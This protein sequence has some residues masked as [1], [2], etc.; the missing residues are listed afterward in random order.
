MCAILYKYIYIYARD[1]AEYFGKFI[2]NLELKYGLNERRAN[3]TLSMLSIIFGGIAVF[4]GEIFVP[5]AVAY[6]SAL[7]V[8]DKTKKHILTL[9]VG[10]VILVINV[11]GIIFSGYISLAGIMIAAVSSVISFYVIRDRSKNECVLIVTV[12]FTLLL[13]ASFVLALMSEAGQFSFEA[14]RAIYNELYESIRSGFVDSLAQ[15]TAGLGEEAS[16]G[17]ISTEDM[18]MIFDS[19]ANLIIAFA[20]IASFAL[21][22][23]S[24]RCFNFVVERNA[25]KS[26]RFDEWRFLPP[27]IF[28]YFYVAVFLISFF[29]SETTV[30]SVAVNNLV[31]IFMAIFLYPGFKLTFAFLSTFRSRGFAYVAIIAALMLFSTVTLEFISMVGVF[32]SAN[33]KIRGR[34]S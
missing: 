4:V 2:M 34:E 6:L 1:C 17:L 3:A 25:V 21:A 24:F 29:L 18:S 12:I 11:L 32:F 22:G 13:A 10:A 9:S 8:F 14:A 7:A 16:S 33:F 5:L 15:M 27:S 28:G 31:Y 30:F 26:T 23:F 19:V 20:V